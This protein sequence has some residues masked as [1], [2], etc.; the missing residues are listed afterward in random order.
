MSPSQLLRHVTAVLKTFPIL[1]IVSVVS[2]SKEP[3]GHDDS[4]ENGTPISQIDALESL[5]LDADSFGLDVFVDTDASMDGFFPYEKTKDS[6][7]GNLLVRLSDFSTLFPKIDDVQYFQ[8]GSK[9]VPNEE[10][11]VAPVRLIELDKTSRFTFRGNYSRETE[12]SDIV[13]MMNPNRVTLLVTSLQESE[14]NLSGFV[15]SLGKWMDSSV[16]DAQPL[17][18]GFACALVRVNLPYT[19]EYSDSNAK[20]G[21]YIPVEDYQKSCFF[22]FIGPRNPVYLSLTS[23]VELN[24]SI[25]TDEITDIWI[26]AEKPLIVP[27]SGFLDTEKS[28]EGVPNNWSHRGTS[29]YQGNITQRYGC[30][31]DSAILD[32]G[33][34]LELLPFSISPSNENAFLL[35]VDTVNGRGGDELSPPSVELITSHVICDKYNLNTNLELTYKISAHKKNNG[36]YFVKT[37]IVPSETQPIPKWIDDWTS[38]PEFLDIDANPQK[39]LPS[40]SLKPFALRLNALFSKELSDNQLIFVYSLEIDA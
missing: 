7:L 13:D 31:H 1:L 9:R 30:H 28:T 34:D 37:T 17:E 19:G 29:E 20:V 26:I 38:I 12:I 21:E 18:A 5:K 39:K 16:R 36:Y 25:L 14:L 23:F 24:R 8:L 3:F 33:I 27:E 35:T 11:E 22:I 32:L 6:D 15:R 40:N 4:M 10:K 2:C